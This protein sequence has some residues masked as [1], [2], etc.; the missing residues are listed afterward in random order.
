MKGRNWEEPVRE[1]G[2]LRK[3]GGGRRD[4]RCL[5][6]L[7]GMRLLACN[8]LPV[9][10]KAQVWRLPQALGRLLETLP[11]AGPS[12]AGRPAVVASAGRRGQRGLWEQQ[13]PLS[14][15]CLMGTRRLPDGRCA[16]GCEITRGRLTIVNLSRRKH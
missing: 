8:S 11:C 9:S 2:A 13:E 16:A 1:A 14:Q 5:T 10:R 4:V 6:Q 3:G 7:R 12:G 15:S